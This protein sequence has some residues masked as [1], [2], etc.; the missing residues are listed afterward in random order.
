M[1]KDRED[2]CAA[3]HG[4]AESGLSNWT[5]TIKTVLLQRLLLPTTQL[6]TSFFVSRGIQL[7]NLSSMTFHSHF[8]VF[9]VYIALLIKETG[10]NLTFKCQ[11]YAFFYSALRFV[12][13]I[14]FCLPKASY[15]FEIFFLILLR[16]YSN[17]ASW[18]DGMFPA[19]LSVVVTS[20][21]WLLST[22]NIASMTKELNCEFYLI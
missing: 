14:W 15:N 4:F 18:D 7:L 11:G 3:A 21:M 2:W 19:L 16:F 13:I 10:L 22:W 5:T 6:E 17:R 1:V 20:R 9:Y 8:K 12:E